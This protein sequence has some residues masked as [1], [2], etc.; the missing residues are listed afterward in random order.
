MRLSRPKRCVLSNHPTWTKHSNER[1]WI[2]RDFVDASTRPGQTKP[3][4]CTAVSGT[5][6]PLS[7]EPRW[8]TTSKK[9]AKGG[10][11]MR[12]STKQ[13]NPSS[14]PKTRLRRGQDPDQTEGG[15]RLHERV[16]HQYRS[17]DWYGLHD[18]YPLRLWLRAGLCRRC[19]GL[20]QLT[21]EYQCYTFW[22]Q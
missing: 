6:L 17:A 11:I 16:L 20:S 15:C 2:K 4:S 22:L 8:R 13:S 7:D 21:P 1:S 14:R 18:T 5:K 10:P 12:T 19:H 3:G 9:G